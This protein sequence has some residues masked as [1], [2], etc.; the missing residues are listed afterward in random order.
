MSPLFPRKI[1]PHRR[2]RERERERENGLPAAKVEKGA[3]CSRNRWVCGG[4]RKREEGH[5]PDKIGKQTMGRGKLPKSYT[6]AVLKLR[7]KMLKRL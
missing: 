4:R 1:V 5:K 6:Y 2:E 7:A 3:Q